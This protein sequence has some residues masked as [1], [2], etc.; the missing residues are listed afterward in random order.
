MSGLS[1][2]ASTRQMRGSQHSNHSSSKRN[3]SS[4]MKDIKV[5]RLTIGSRPPLYANA[6]DRTQLALPYLLP[7]GKSPEFHPLRAAKYH[8]I[9][10]VMATI[11]TISFGSTPLILL[12][13]TTNFA[14]NFSKPR[15]LT[16]ASSK[17]SVPENRL[18][19]NVFKTILL[20]PRDKRD[21]SEK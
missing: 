11:F 3:I 4:T 17:S 19:K 18:F 20:L 9:V 8:S 2:G 14:N 10:V 1:T 16:E 13:T 21:H 15:S 6:S 12:G 5:L 7:F